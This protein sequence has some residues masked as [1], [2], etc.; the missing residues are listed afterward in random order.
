MSAREGI[1]LTAR[2]LFVLVALVVFFAWVAW[3]LVRGGRH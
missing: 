3:E 1:L 2:E